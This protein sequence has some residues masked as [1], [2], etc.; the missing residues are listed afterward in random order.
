[1]R[2]IDIDLDFFLDDVVY[3][4]VFER[5]NSDDYKPWKAEAVR[6]FLEKQ[7]GLSTNRRISGRYV[8]KHDEAFLFWKELI[9][10]GLLRAPFDV[11]HIDA[12]SD[13]G[14]GDG[15][16]IYLM[17]DILHR[18]INDR[19]NVERA[20]GKLNEGNYL[21][22]AVACQWIRKLTYIPNS[23]SRDDLLNVHFKD[24]DARTS[25]IQLKRATRENLDDFLMTFPYSPP[26]ECL[27]PEVEFSQIPSEAL[28]EKGPFDFAV[29]CH[30]HRFTPPSADSLVPVIMEYIDPI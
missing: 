17:T 28:N 7:C 9:E 15:G 29:L 12:H 10:K 3:M 16:F 24:C 20:S 25:I 5:P 22:F 6:L 26:S 18:E 19:T 1:M 14:T 11:V 23:K 30:S 13:L 8:E 21:A 27:E 4:P 2:V